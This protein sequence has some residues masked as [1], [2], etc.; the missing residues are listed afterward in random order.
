[1]LAAA[2]YR[3]GSHTTI[4]CS[5][6]KDERTKFKKKQKKIKRTPFSIPLPRS[7]DDTNNTE[8]R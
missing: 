8:Q 1:M 2:L 5:A 7:L 3:T 4:Q 6:Q